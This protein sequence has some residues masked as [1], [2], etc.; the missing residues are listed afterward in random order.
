MLVEY[1]IILTLYYNDLNVILPRVNSF[2]IKQK[3]HF[4]ICHKRQTRSGKKIK[5]NKTQQISVKT[6]D[7]FVKTKLQ[8][9]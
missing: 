3:R 9:N 6:Q 1:Y 8:H 7:F 2:D 4:F 5:A